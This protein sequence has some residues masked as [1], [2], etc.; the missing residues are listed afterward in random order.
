ML[1]A[2]M[3]TIAVSCVHTNG[4]LGDGLTLEFIGEAVFPT[5]F[6]YSGFEVGGLSGI[7]YDPVSNRYIAI[8]DDRAQYGPV[9]FFELQINL[10]DAALDPGDVVFTGVTQILDKNDAAFAPLAVD[11]EAIRFSPV[12]GTLYWTS[13]GDANTGPFVRV[14][15]RDGHHVD[16]FLPPPNYLPTALTGT[17][18]NMTFESLAF[19]HDA[20]SVFTATENALRQDGPHASITAGSPVR[21]LALDT[22]NGQ[23]QAE[24]VYLT[25]AVVAAPDPPGAF[26]TNGLVELLAFD[27]SHLL[28]LERSYSTGVGN[29]VRLFLTTT[30]FVTD[31]RG[32]DSIA[33]HDIRTMPKELLLDLDQ[34]DLVLDNIEGMTFGPVLADGK[35]TLILVSDNNFNSRGGQFTQFLAFRLAPVER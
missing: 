8:S 2:V 28:A 16:E 20:L 32:M 15:T 14:M 23:A 3:A 17:R 22:D 18:E 10:S 35:R 7:D 21:V 13:E 1:F 9:R 25:E 33:Q 27:E 4:Q 11:P 5:G 19:S 12:A 34:L 6:Q 29:S 24:Y 26:A 30:Q 31:V